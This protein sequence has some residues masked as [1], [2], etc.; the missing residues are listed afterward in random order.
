M[1]AGQKVVKITVIVGHTW[2]QMAE[3]QGADGGEERTDTRHI[4]E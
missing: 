1:G 3:G 2:G 4:S